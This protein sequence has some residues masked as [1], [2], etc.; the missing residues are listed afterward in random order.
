MIKGKGWTPGTLMD[1]GGMEGVGLTFLEET[2]SASTAP[3]EHRVHQ[4]AARAVLKTLLPKTGTEIKGGMRSR[5][6]LLKAS[7]YADKP[8]DFEHLL[9][10]TPQPNLSQGMHDFE[11]GFASNFNRRH[12]RVGPVFQG[13][14]HAVVVER[15]A[16]AWEL[17]RYI[18]L[19]PVRHLTPART[20]G[21][22]SS[23]T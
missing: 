2:F 12:G 22:A 20:R 7:E 18:H 21:P 3:P 9:L 11:G 4:K 10:R 16:H 14:F 5:E 15:D 13:R 23:T 8:R 6:D 17:S 19:N 1:V